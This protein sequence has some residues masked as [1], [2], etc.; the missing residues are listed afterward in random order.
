MPVGRGSLDSSTTGPGSRAGRASRACGRFRRRSSGA[1]RCC[2]ARAA[3]AADGRRADRRRRPRAGAGG[4]ATTGEPAPVRGAERAAAAP[5]SRCCRARRRRRVRCPPRRDARG[6]TAT[7][8]SR[9]RA[10]QRARARAARCTGRTRSTSRRCDA[11]A[12]A[13]VGTHDFTAFTPTETDHVRFE[14][15]VSRR[16]LAARSRGERA[17]VLDRGRRVHAPHEPRAGGDDARGRRRA[18][19]ASTSFAALLD[20][21][22]A[23]G[24]RAD[25]AAHGLY[26]AGVG[27]GGERVLARL[28][29]GSIRARAAPASRSCR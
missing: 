28:T 13:L 29:R 19:V 7:G 21:R 3:V 25:R 15:D 1:R 11:C 27:Y 26:L 14:R 6:P 20:G 23:V 12:A 24:G 4:V 17:R 5:T 9:G 10:A 18:A 22:A 2:C 16:V 8:C